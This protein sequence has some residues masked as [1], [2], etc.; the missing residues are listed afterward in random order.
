MNAAQR[1]EEI[2]DM[3]RAVRHPLSASTIARKFAVSRQVIVGDIALMRASGQNILAT[4]RGYILQ[5]QE[6]ENAYFERSL[7]CAHSAQELA[8]EIYTI[9]DHGGALIDVTVEHSVYGEIC[10]PLH[11]YSRFDAE[12]FLKKVE[13]AQAH[14]LSALTDGAHLHKIRCIDEQTFGR[15]ERALQDKG[16]LFEKDEG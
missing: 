15:I 3:L 7:A 11:L 5:A 16:L 8:E 6:E 4:P 10:A 12:A 13:T 2:G 14:P 9:I 1:R